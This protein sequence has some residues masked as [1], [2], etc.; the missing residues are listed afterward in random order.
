MKIIMNVTTHYKGLKLNGKEYD[1]DS[2]TAQRWEANGIGIIVEKGKV[3]EAVNNE[4]V[5]DEIEEVEEEDEVEE[6]E[7]VVNDE[8][9]DYTKMSAK[10]LYDLCKE[11]DL[12]VKAKRPKTYYIEKLEELE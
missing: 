4:D 3:E 9:T 10:R 2:V 12:D 6:I 7:E 8:E 5:G 1:V 11:K